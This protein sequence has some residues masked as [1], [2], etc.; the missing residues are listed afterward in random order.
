MKTLD[1]EAEILPDGTLR[2]L[3]PRP[4]WLEPGRRRV[5]LV[6]DEPAPG[7]SARIAPQATPEM[8]AQRKQALAELRE[9]GGLRDIVP[10]PLEWQREIRADRPLPNRG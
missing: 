10:D 4:D 3:S 1:T 2:L 8:L 6:I 5:L 7:A 9:L